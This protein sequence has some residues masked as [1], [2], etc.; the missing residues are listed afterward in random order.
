MLTGTFSARKAVLKTHPLNLAV[1]SSLT[2][3]LIL[4]QSQHLI[5]KYFINGR[6]LNTWNSM[7]LVP[8]PKAD[9]SCSWQVIQAADLKL[10]WNGQGSAKCFFVAPS[11][12]LTN[13][14][15]AHLF[16]L[17]VF[18]PLFFQKYLGTQGRREH[19]QVGNVLTFNPVFFSRTTFPCCYNT[20]QTKC[21][22]CRAFSVHRP[23]SLEQT[24]SICM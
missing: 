9:T 5:V 11:Q 14:W 24:F 10:A 12:H 20:H 2:F 22:V 15:V 18:F 13:Y 7:V 3:S 21:K 4:P 19:L 1:T 23:M 16:S 8:C 17:F 6:S